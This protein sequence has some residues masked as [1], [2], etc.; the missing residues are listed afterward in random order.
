MS[1]PANAVDFWRG[2]ALVE[3]FINHIPGNFWERFTHKALSQ[4]D[5]AELFVFL[6]GWSLS[7]VVGPREDP[8]STPRLVFRL[9]LRAG[10]LYAAHMV[11]VMMAIAMLAA[12]SRWLDDPLILEWFNASAVFYEPVETH[13]GLIFLSHQLGYFDILPLY[14]VLLVASPAIAV[15]HRRWPAALL[16]VSLAI[17]GAALVSETTFRTWPTEGE[18]FFN[19]LCWQLSF[20][21]GYLLARKD[22]AAGWVWRH[23][24]VLRWIA[25]PILVAAAVL[26]WYGIEADPTAVP[27]P[28]LV[29]VD[30]KSFLT[31]SRILQ[32]LVLAAVV[33][34]VY[35][36]ID[37]HLPRLASALSLLG[38][39][40]L[41]IFCTGS[42]L[43]LAG[44]IVRFAF[45]GGGVALDTGLLIAGLAVFFALAK[46]AE[47]WERAR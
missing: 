14:V 35:P 11:I 31:P 38:R 29:F 18:W 32:F 39:N 7:Y 37:R 17:Y 30:A 10:T 47:W 26:R 2:F 24:G 23:I 27:E 41:L 21:L 25:L 44:Q 22:G 43:S 42:V 15:L 8:R 5:S 9:F 20:V 28:H 45:R 46:A 19:P 3:I 34:A 12:A 4:S 13:I 6:A 36:R 40:S 33:S 16:P 1:R